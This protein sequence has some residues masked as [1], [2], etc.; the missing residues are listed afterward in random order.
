M[1]E[2]E[3]SLTKSGIKVFVKHEGIK[4]SIL[5]LYDRKGSSTKSG[6]TNC[7]KHYVCYV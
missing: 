1:E 7:V 5:F 4:L 3:I 2:G 6:M